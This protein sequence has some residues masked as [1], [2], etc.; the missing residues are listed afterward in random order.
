MNLSRY[1]KKKGGEVHCQFIFFKA[2]MQNRRKIVDKNRLRFIIKF[3]IIYIKK[4]VISRKNM[5]LAT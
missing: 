4:N 1:I 5:E 3:Q 2:K